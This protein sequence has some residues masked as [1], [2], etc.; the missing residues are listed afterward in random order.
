MISQLS[1]MGSTHIISLVLAYAG[2]SGSSNCTVTV[3]AQPKDETK[4]EAHG[5]QFAGPC[6]ELDAKLPELL[7][8]AATKVVALNIDLA[9]LDKQITDAKTA[10]TAKLDAET[11]KPAAATVASTPKGKGKE[12]KPAA[13]TSTTTM[14]DASED[15]AAATPPAKK[16]AASALV[17][18]PGPTQITLEEL[19][20]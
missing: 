8:Q 20:P 6:A 1:P 19:F 11:A 4:H 10:R 13:P 5:I 9:S 3:L 7:A 2:E 14:D 18:A 12:A 17:A 15:S 16:P